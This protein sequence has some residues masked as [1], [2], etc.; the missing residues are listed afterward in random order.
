MSMNSAWAMVMG[1]VDGPTLAER[2][3]SGP[4]L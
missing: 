2:I 1:L 3:R 4:M